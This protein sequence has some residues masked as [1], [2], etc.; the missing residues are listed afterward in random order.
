MPPGYRC[1]ACRR[2]ETGIGAHRSD[3]DIAYFIAYFIAYLIAYLIAYAIAE[4]RRW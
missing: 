3:R 1:V 2:D 4:L